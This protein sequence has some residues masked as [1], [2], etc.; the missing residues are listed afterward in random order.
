M[1]NVPTLFTLF[2]GSTVRHL[3]IEGNDPGV[4]N[5]SQLVDGVRTVVATGTSYEMN[6]KADFIVEE[7]MKKESFKYKKHGD[8]PVFE[9]LKDAVTLALLMGHT[10]VFDPKS[11][12]GLNNPLGQVPLAS[13]QGWQ[14]KSGSD[15]EYGFTGTTLYGQPKVTAKHGVNLTPKD[16]A[17]W[18]ANVNKALQ[19][20]KAL[21]PE[22]EFLLC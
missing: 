12:K 18:I 22:H 6:K 11:A 14:D 21:G 17:E 4:M 8:P 15:Y 9:S 3:L 5:L 13:W 16:N 2:Q 19:I 7:W 20:R 1:R 10:G